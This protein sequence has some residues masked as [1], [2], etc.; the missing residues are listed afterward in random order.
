MKLEILPVDHVPEI[1][2]GMD[3]GKCLAEATRAS[4]L[5]LFETDIIAV[6]QKIV[7]KAEGRIVHLAAVEPSPQSLAVA[8]RMSKDPRLVELI[9]RE[10][11]RIVRMRGE[12][13]ITETE[14]GFICANAGIDQ[15]NVCASETVTLLPKDPDRSA[16]DIAR[17]LG[18]GVIITDTFG[19]AWREGLLDAAI[20]IAGIPP[21]ID[22]RGKQDSYGHE[23]HVTLLAAADALSAA[24]GLAMGKTSRTPAAVIR[25]FS[26]QRTE[27]NATA[28]L[29]PVERDLFL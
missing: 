1:T 17:S 13:I 11:R 29:R 4:G 5:T 25:G 20:G 3:L 12:V 19:R 27:S 16:R 24:A 8:R 9:F 23:L 26:W 2:P 28:L 14:H 21:F 10:S 18:C 15:S 6:T 22:F 7:S